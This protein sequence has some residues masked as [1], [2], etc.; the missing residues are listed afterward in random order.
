MSK[1]LSGAELWWA[2]ARFVFANI[3]DTFIPAGTSSISRNPN[4]SAAT[5]E[6]S[7]HLNKPVKVFVCQYHNHA[8]VPDIRM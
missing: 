4:Q 1:L 3:C 6:Q 2:H 5:G 8:V 7:A